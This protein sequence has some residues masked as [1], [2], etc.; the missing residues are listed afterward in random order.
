MEKHRHFMNFDIAGFTYWDGALVL[1]DLK[2]GKKVRLEREEDNKHDPYAVAIWFG[3][4]KLGFIPRDEN[5]QI[6]KFLE[7]GYAD[8][9]DARIQR[10][11]PD[12]HPEHQ[13]SVII[14]LNRNKEDK[15]CVD[16]Q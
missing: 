13:V 5:H 9:F 8:I 16:E 12:E 3:E 6:S 4:N 15:V 1:C 14:Y 7:M 2:P 10:V 11:S